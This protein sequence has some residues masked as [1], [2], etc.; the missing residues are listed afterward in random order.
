MS[1]FSDSDELRPEQL[2]LVKETTETIYKLMAETPP[3]GAEF[4]KGVKHILQVWF[5]SSMMW[6]YLCYWPDIWYS[7]RVA[8]EHLEK[9]RLPRVQEAADVRQSSIWIEAKTEA[10]QTSWGSNPRGYWEQKIPHGKV[11][12]LLECW[13]SFTWTLLSVPSWQNF[14]IKPATIWRRAV[15]KSATS[16]RLLRHTS[17]RL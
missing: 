14:G 3:H 4:A 15:P 17:R 10:S 7:E 1:V 5:R 2:E 13:S 11:C 8:L 12:W 9:R 6:C 16:T